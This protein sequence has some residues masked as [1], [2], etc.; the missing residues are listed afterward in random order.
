MKTWI[1]RK[2][3][4]AQITIMNSPKKI[5]KFTVILHWNLIQSNAIQSNAIQSDSIWSD[6]IWSDLIWPKVILIDELQDY[7]IEAAMMRLSFAFFNLETRYTS[8]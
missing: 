1:V 7:V 5:V 6:L 3:L 8:H 4:M 2:K